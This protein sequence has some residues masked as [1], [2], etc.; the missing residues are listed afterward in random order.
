MVENIV[1]VMI[2]AGLGSVLRYLLLVAWPNKNQYLT[3]VWAVNILGSFVLGALATYHWGA[4]WSAFLQTGFLG[5]LTTFS[6]MLTQS[7]NNK[8]LV[9]Q[10]FYLVIQV[11][12]GILTFLLGQVLAGNFH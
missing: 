4:N 11:V 7:K 5:G 3:G 8:D 2:G 1:L 9:K 10:G 6:T 12:T